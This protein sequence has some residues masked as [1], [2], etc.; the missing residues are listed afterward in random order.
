MTKKKVSQKELLRRRL[1]S[2]R[3][4]TLADGTRMSKVKGG[5]KLELPND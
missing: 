5:Y 3:V 2:K 1:Q 4:I